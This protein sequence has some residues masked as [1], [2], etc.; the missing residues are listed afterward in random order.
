MK[1]SLLITAILVLNFSV[2]A[3]NTIEEIS[4][5]YELTYDLTNA[6]IIDKLT[7]N[8]DGSF[9]FHTYEKI[10]KRHIPEGNK[11]GKGT[12]RAD[13]N[14]IYFTTTEADFY[15]KYTLDF[16]NTKARFFT[17]SPRDSSD[18]D[19]KTTIQFYES[20]ISWIVKRKLLKKD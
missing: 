6:L 5:F 4:G 9:D 19:I 15:E 11:Y 7:L 20:E 2:F 1:K 12:W 17:K 3:Q 14:L 10:E 16:N 13:R 18:R 8:A